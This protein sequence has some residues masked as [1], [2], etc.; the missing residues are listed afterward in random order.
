[1]VQSRL[2]THDVLQVA[3]TLPGASAADL[4]DDDD[5]FAVLVAHVAEAKAF[6]RTRGWDKLAHIE[7]FAAGAT[8]A[9]R[10]L[11]RFDDDGT[12]RRVVS[13]LWPLLPVGTR[14]R[15]AHELPAAVDARAPDFF[16]HP[17]DVPNIASVYCDFLAIHSSP[18]DVER[19]LF[20]AGAGPLLAPRAV[21]PGAA[22]GTCTAVTLEQRAIVPA[23]S[24]PPMV[25]DSVVPTWRCI[26]TRAALGL[27]AVAVGSANDG[28]RVRVGPDGVALRAVDG[29]EQPITVGNDVLAAW[30]FS[31]GPDARGLDLRS[32]DDRAL[33]LLWAHALRAV[34]IEGKSAFAWLEDAATPL[35]LRAR[36]VDSAVT[37]A[38]DVVARFSV[39]AIACRITLR[40]TPGDGGWTQRAAAALDACALFHDVVARGAAATPARDIVWLDTFLRPGLVGGRLTP[41]AAGRAFARLA[42]SVLAPLG[43]LP[44]SGFKDGSGAVLLQRLVEETAN[45]ASHE[46]ASEVQ[47]RGARLG[48]R[49]PRLVSFDDTGAHDEPLFGPEG[50]W[51]AGRGLALPDP[52]GAP[53]HDVLAMPA[54]L[55]FFLEGLP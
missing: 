28:W 10:V 13:M 45:D 32:E 21:C 9:A 14:T 1:M 31:A 15:V 41:L 6:L 23:S 8:L 34:T 25:H 12:R 5:D 26:I 47:A 19:D 4:V 18:G 38:I 43:V 42:T 40:S 49:P 44:L 29:R 48:R 2:L 33:L 50:A 51:A 7:R 17:G 46:S 36:V 24:L 16:L 3:D 39:D 54:W 53:R 22:R 30:L 35:P 37:C 52:K 27:D 20:T 11:G 55:A